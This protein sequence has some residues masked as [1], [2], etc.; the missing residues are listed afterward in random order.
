MGDVNDH[1]PLGNYVS[2]LF[3][4]FRFAEHSTGKQPFAYIDAPS[5]AYS[6]GERGSRQ[7]PRV[8]SS[9]M[10]LSSVVRITLADP[11]PS[12]PPRFLVG[13]QVGS[14]SGDV[15]MYEWHRSVSSVYVSI[16]AEAEISQRRDRCSWQISRPILDRSGSVWSCNSLFVGAHNHFRHWLGL[17][18]QLTDMS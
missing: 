8:V 4:Q 2:R 6:T 1:S 17:P 18:L 12:E 9:I 13:G 14:A 3:R 7:P 16:R 15:K 5:S 10:S 11:I